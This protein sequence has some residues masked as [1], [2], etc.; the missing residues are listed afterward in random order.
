MISTIANQYFLLVLL[1]WLKQPGELSC[2]K[3]IKV[4]NHCNTE[5]IYSSEQKYLVILYM[6]LVYR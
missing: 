1:K 5:K 4:C 6:N 2:V 3:S